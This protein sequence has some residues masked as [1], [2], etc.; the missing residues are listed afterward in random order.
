MTNAEAATAGASLLPPTSRDGPSRPGSLKRHRP[1]GRRRQIAGSKRNGRRA[2]MKR[3]R[4][5]KRGRHARGRSRLKRRRGTKLLRD[6]EHRRCMR[7]PIRFRSLVKR[8]IRTRRSEPIV[9][10]APLRRRS[11]L[12][13]RRGNRKPGPAGRNPSRRWTSRLTRGSGHPQQ[14]RRS[15][16]RRIAKARSNHWPG[17]R[18]DRVHQSLPSTRCLWIWRRPRHRCAC[19]RMRID[20]LLQRTRRLRFRPRS[21]RQR[22]NGLESVGTVSRPEWRSSWIATARRRPPTATSI[23]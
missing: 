17:R 11:R 13:N 6:A 14:R 7:R 8:R 1:I 23:A 19:S 15:S 22:P 18:G 3:H 2:P 20:P 21:K 9:R 10:R 4:Y 16:W 5:D 12:K